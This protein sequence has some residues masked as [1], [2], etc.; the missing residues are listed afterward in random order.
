MQGIGTAARV[1]A[2]VTTGRGVR[3]PGLVKGTKP[4]AVPAYAASLAS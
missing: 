3:P 1:Q 4:A 2:I